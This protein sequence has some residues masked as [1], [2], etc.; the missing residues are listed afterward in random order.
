MN[1]VSGVATV[2]DRLAIFYRS[3]RCRK[4]LAVCR[5]RLV[6]MWLAV[7]ASLCS[8]RV[9]LTSVTALSLMGRLKVN[10]AKWVTS[11]WQLRLCE[12][13]ILGMMLASPPR[14]ILIPRKAL[15]GC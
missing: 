4:V 1:H 9:C 2:L 3:S 8:C 11:V 15:I 7:Y 5:S 10:E 13:K 14:L 6:R 12:M